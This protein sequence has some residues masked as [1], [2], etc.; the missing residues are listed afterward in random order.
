[1]HQGFDIYE[2]TWRNKIDLSKAFSNFILCVVSSV[3]LLINLVIILNK[4]RIDYYRTIIFTKQNIMCHYTYTAIKVWNTFYAKGFAE[5]CLRRHSVGISLFLNLVFLPPYF[6]LIL[7]IM[8]MASCCSN[9]LL[10]KTCITTYPYF[11]W[12]Y[13]VFSHLLFSFFIR[14]WKLLLLTL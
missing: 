12:C 2:N 10:V 3:L 5:M 11:L 8:V 13:V 7:S 1:M 9:F 14:C 6:L 4:L